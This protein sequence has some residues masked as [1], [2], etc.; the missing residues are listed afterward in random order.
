M[1]PLGFSVDFLATCIS[2]IKHTITSDTPYLHDSYPHPVLRKKWV[3]WVPCN[4]PGRWYP[5]P[6]TSPRK[7]QAPSYSNLGITALRNTAPTHSFPSLYWKPSQSTTSPSRSCSRVANS[8]HEPLL[9]QASHWLCRALAIS[10]SCSTWVG[11]LNPSPGAGK[12]LSDNLWFSA[13]TNYLWRRVRAQPDLPA[14]CSS[15][16]AGRDMGIGAIGACTSYLGAFLTARSLCYHK[17]GLQAPC[18]YIPMPCTRLRV[19]RWKWNFKEEPLLLNMPYKQHFCR[20]GLV[21]RATTTV[22]WPREDR[23]NM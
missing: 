1:Q 19:S 13:T 2:S 21:Y 10:M 7:G 16:T 14:P 3:N 9:H 23:H 8:K 15:A 11:F 22:T 5:S 12:D 20:Y 18:R 17:W 4:N 6:P